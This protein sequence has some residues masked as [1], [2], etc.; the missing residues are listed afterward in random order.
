MRT[1]NAITFAN[2]S[3]FN[4]GTFLNLNS[5][6]NSLG[7][8]NA[9]PVPLESDALPIVVSGLFMAG[10]VWFKRKRN[11]AKVSEFLADETDK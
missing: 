4:T 3:S 11:Q 7:V 8:S 10:G 9:T 6:T 1:A 2:G 5:Q